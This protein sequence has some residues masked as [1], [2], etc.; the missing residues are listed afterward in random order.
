MQRFKLNAGEILTK[1][2]NNHKQTSHQKGHDFEK[3][4]A[5][6]AK[7]YFD[8]DV[9]EKNILKNGLKVK[10]PYEIDVH[11]IKNITS[12]GWFGNNVNRIDILIECKNIKS[13]IKRT[14][15]FKLLNTAKDIYEAHKASREEFHFDYFAIVSASKFDIDALSYAGDNDIACFQY[16]GKKY[17][18]KNEP[19]WLIN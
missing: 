17:E 3:K 8:A 16:D 2:K 19:S 11:V 18:L 5:R 10:R 14:H 4:V 1:K 13:S 15:V 9:V 7:R 12:Q 6:W